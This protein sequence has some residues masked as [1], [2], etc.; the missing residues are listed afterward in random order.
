M[1][2]QN[3]TSDF[4]REGCIPLAILELLAF[5]TET[6]TLSCDPDHMS[7]LKKFQRSCWDCPWGIHATF[8]VHIFSQFGATVLAFNPQNYGVT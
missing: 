8:E 1:S 3:L 7:H 2:P 6:F 5:N 4:C